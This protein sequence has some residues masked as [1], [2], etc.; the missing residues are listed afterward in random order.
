MLLRRRKML[1]NIPRQNM[2][3]HIGDN[4]FKNLSLFSITVG[5]AVTSEPSAPTYLFRGLKLSCQRNILLAPNLLG[6]IRLR[7]NYQG[8]FHQCTKLL[9]VTNV[10]LIVLSDPGVLSLRNTHLESL[11]LMQDIMLQGISENSRGLFL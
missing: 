11:D 6:S 2:F 4:S 5:R 8:M 7:G 1:K 3:L 10:E 9:L